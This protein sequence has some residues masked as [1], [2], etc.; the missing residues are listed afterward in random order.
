MTCLTCLELIGFGLLCFSQIM[1]GVCMMAAI[2]VTQI[3]C[4]L[5]VAAKFSSNIHG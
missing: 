3:L 5:A 1:F 2:N 4:S